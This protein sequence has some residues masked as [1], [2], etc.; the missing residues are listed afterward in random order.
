MTKNIIN[1][2]PRTFP[3]VPY[4]FY[5]S[6][7]EKPSFGSHV[8]VDNFFDFACHRQFVLVLWWIWKLLSALYSRVLL[9]CYLRHWWL[10]YYLAVRKARRRQCKI[11][12][13]RARTASKMLSWQ[14]F[15]VGE[16]FNSSDWILG[17][18]FDVVQCWWNDGKQAVGNTQEIFQPDECHDPPPLGQAPP[19][20][21]TVPSLL[22]L[23]C[24]LSVPQLPPLKPARPAPLPRC[25]SRRKKRIVQERDDGSVMETF[26]GLTP[27]IGTENDG[28]LMGFDSCSR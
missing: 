12:R 27:T 2:Y 15:P 21:I 24:D 11:M 8:S 19:K 14:Y 3:P 25:S 26:S 17:P 4:L 28:T 6:S 9:L 1:I 23:D 20:I 5:I 7:A 18:S 22:C 16:S 10:D 13:Y